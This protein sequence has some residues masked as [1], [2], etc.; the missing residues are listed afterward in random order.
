ME[1]YYRYIKIYNNVYGNQKTS[2]SK[3]IICDDFFLGNLL[4]YKS[5]IFIVINCDFFFLSNVH[6][7]LDGQILLTDLD[8]NSMNRS[9][10]RCVRYLKCMI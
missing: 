4:S 8:W 5:L 3:K 7:I 2:T 9:Y 6:R 10:N 1:K